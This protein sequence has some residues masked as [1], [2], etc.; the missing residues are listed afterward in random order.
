MSR[1]QDSPQVRKNAG[2]IEVML[3]MTRTEFEKHVAHALD[4][5]PPELASL[6]DNVAIFVFDDPPGDQPSDL[7]G[8][9][10]GIPLTER[11][12]SYTGVLP[13]RISIFMNPTLAIC[14]TAADVIEEV[15]ITVVHEIAHH[16]GID[17]EHLHE[18][19]YA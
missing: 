12:S 17:D 5:I 14:D 2:R 19:G 18:L 11:D 10:E 8:V 1:T 15:E 4:R 16:F 9:Y 3:A 13:D 7:L 6:M